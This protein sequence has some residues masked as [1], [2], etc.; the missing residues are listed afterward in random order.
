MYLQH[1]IMSFQATPKREATRPKRIKTEV[2]DEA[3]NLMKKEFDDS[4][5]Q[6]DIQVPSVSGD[7]DESLSHEQSADRDRSMKSSGTYAEPSR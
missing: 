6:K 3:G 1:R 5:D 2:K 7:F 4:A